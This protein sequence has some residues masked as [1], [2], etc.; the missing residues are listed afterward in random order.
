MVC[1]AAKQLNPR[2]RVAPRCH[3]L[4]NTDNLP[5]AGADIVISP[6]FTGARRISSAMIRP[7]VVPLLDEMLCTERRVRLDEV[8]VPEQ[9]KSRPL[10]ACICAV[11][12]TCS[13]QYARPRTGYSIRMAASDCGRAA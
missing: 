11:P 12:N 13:W 2:G 1:L 7:H 9:F 5:K 8:E 4:R 3:E 10:G 6:D